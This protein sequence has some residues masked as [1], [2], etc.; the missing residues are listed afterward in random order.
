MSRSVLPSQFTLASRPRYPGRT[1]NLNLT[2][3]LHTHSEIIEVIKRHLL[4]NGYGGNFRT[5][6][7]DDTEYTV[8]SLPPTYG[9]FDQQGTSRQINLPLLIRSR[10]LEYAV[11]SI[12]EACRLLRP[13][14]TTF[15]Y[16]I[17][18]DVYAQGIPVQGM[19][20]VPRQ[21]YRIDASGKGQWHEVPG[22]YRDEYQA[23][24]NIRSALASHSYT[25]GTFFYGS[26]WYAV[27]DIV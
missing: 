14:V 9:I 4:D 12:R 17:Q 1:C 23:I 24:D 3:R 8:D 13:P 6:D 18:Y 20:P 26:A 2:N 21:W 10:E 11:E 19:R 16:G 7:Y 5:F 25:K 15:W 27:K 22:A